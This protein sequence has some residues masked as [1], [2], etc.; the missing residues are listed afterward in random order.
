MSGRPGA[1]V[2]AALV[3]NPTL[4]ALYC[5]GVFVLALEAELGAP[6]AEISA[7]FAVAVASFTVGIVLAPYLYRVAPAAVHLLA[8]AVLSVAGLAYAAMADQVWQLVLGYG[9]L[10]GFAGGYAYSVTLQLITLALSARRGLATGLGVGSFAIGSILLTM[11][12]APTVQVFGPAT[13]LA[14]M[15]ALIAAASLLA[16]LLAK[17]SGLVLPDA[18]QY[19]AMTES[20]GFARVFPLLWLGFLLGAFAGVMTIGH[21]AGI[22][23]NLGGDAG[24][25]VFGTV[26]INLG[27]AGGR[28]AAGALCDRF[29]PARI[30][31][32]AH[33]SAVLG[34]VLLLLWPEPGAAVTALGFEGLA[35]GLASGAYPGAIGIYFGVARY[36]RL[37]GFLLTAWG[38]AGLV[39]PWLAGRLYDLSGN[40]A[41][42]LLIGFAAAVAG[43]LLSFAIPPPS[44]T[45]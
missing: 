36:G 20:D 14:L 37:L 42:S 27:N 17:L 13:G 43:L 15:A 16:A 12:F 28:L 34:F 4:G 45:A 19:L 44:R 6:R 33:L 2:A 10:F 8:A 41:S 29:P 26:V 7:V 5:F 18:R 24:L 23:V 30:A 39:G 22:V 25:A 40:Y 32:L 38:L 1:A 3:L 31:G 21:S 11:L 35:Y 9:G